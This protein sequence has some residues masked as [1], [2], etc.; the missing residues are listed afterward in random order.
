MAA[1]G[2]RSPHP[3]GPRLRRA[4]KYPPTPP[5]PITA[6]CQCPLPLAL[7][8]HS[9]RRRR[10][11]MRVQ[12]SASASFEVG[13]GHAQI[14]RQPERI[15]T[16]ATPTDS[17][18]YGDGPRRTR[19][20]CDQ[21]STFRS[22]GAARRSRRTRPPASG[23][24]PSASSLSMRTT[25]LAAPG[26]TSVALPTVVLGAIERPRPSGGMTCIDE[27]FE[28]LWLPWTIPLIRVPGPPRHSQSASTS[29][30]KPGDPLTLQRA[31]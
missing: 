8:A 2:R 9:A 1:R 13:V 14:G 26:T 28:V 5:A 10:F 19:W 3:P 27:G 31:A 15:C 16:T 24:D 17:R 29:C 18:R 21:A 22:S 4:P 12:A 7:P 11:W 30:I 20:S 25:S 23:G 6:E